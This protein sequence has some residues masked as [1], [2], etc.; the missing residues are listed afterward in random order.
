MDWWSRRAL[1][2]GLD[3]GSDEEATQQHVL[4]SPSRSRLAMPKRTLP[5][6][7]LRSSIVSIFI[8]RERK[9]DIEQIA[10]V[11][12]SMF[13]V[14]R[15]EYFVLHTRHGEVDQAEADTHR[16]SNYLVRYTPYSICN[17]ESVMA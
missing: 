4:S 14:P 6:P 15:T 1:I 10:S 16:V 12:C 17:T 8:E 13:S 5:G 9:R 11:L 7:A 3:F 2:S